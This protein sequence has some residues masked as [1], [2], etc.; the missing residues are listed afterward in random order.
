MLPSRST[1]IGH[2]VEVGMESTYHL[3]VLLQVLVSIER[4]RRSHHCRRLFANC[5]E[6]ETPR[7]AIFWTDLSIVMYTA[8]LDVCRYTCAVFQ[9]QVT[10]TIGP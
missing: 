8:C 5:A 4:S 2:L 6:K 10:P 3:P 7:R 9:I 1:A